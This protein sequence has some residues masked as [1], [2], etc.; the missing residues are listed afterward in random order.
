MASSQPALLFILGAFAVYKGTLTLR[1]ALRELLASRIDLRDPQALQAFL[2]HAERAGLR[3]CYYSI[4]TG[5]VAAE[6]PL[7]DLVGAP[8]AC[9]IHRLEET[10]SVILGLGSCTQLRGQW[11]QEA[12]AWGLSAEASGCAD[13]GQAPALAVELSPGALSA[14]FS[15]PERP[16]GSGRHAL[17]RAFCP[18]P[19]ATARAAPMSWQDV[20][21]SLLSSLSLP[22]LTT[23]S[24]DVLPLGTL[25]SLCGAVTVG[26]RDGRLA[27]RVGPDAAAGLALLPFSALPSPVLA[28]GAG[29]ALA[30]LGLA[31]MRMGWL[32]AGSSSGGSGRGGGAGG[33][34]IESFFHATQDN[35]DAASDGVTPC[36]LCFEN[37]PCIVLQPCGHMALCSACARRLLVTMK[38]TCCPICRGSVRAAAR[39]FTS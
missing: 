15:P 12:P 17:Q 6:S 11:L 32:Q 28:L 3:R 37:R 14:Q 25:V 8:A 35:D 1:A 4:I 33:S 26:A 13:C 24:Q 18:G 20:L 7:L 30:A 21:S 34:A 36:C 27:L 5:Y 16:Q 2:A 22:D 38:S 9:I 39:V 31:L 19:R 29:V 10:R 23:H